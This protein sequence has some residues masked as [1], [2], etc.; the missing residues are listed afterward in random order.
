MKTILRSNDFSCPSC[1]TRIEGA[2]GKLPGVESARVHFSTGRIEV[3]HDT[4]ETPVA[5]LVEAVRELGYE[6]RPSPF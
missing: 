4:N 1:V 6:S 5:T 3:Q 2:L